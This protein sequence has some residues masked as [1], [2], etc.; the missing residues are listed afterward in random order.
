M[1]EAIKKA[2]EGVTQA[3]AIGFINTAMRNWRHVPRVDA[4]D[5]HDLARELQSFSDRRYSTTLEA[6]QRENEE[7]KAWIK[8]ATLEI[9]K[10]IGG[11][12]E[13]FTQHGDEFR[14]DHTFV[15]MYIQC[16]REQHAKSKKASIQK[17]REL[18]ARAET[19]EAEVKRLREALE[20]ISSD[21][22]YRS[23]V[24][25]NAADHI[26]ELQELAYESLASPGE[27]HHAE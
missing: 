8:T 4:D 21:D 3:E 9:T 25:L 23:G 10:A 16:R 18:R 17:E 27:E 26:A 20:Q 14:F 6:L 7:L 12:S 1:V 13:M 22:G 11:G 2:L 15:A 24:L 5:L 19:A